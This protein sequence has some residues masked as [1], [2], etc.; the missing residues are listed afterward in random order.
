MTNIEAAKI[1][2]EWA[3]SGTF[4]WPLD[5]DYDQHIKFSEHR[6]KNWHGGSKEEWRRFILNYADSLL[7]EQ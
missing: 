3:E 2:R 1:L 5:R 4:S 6:N 7:M